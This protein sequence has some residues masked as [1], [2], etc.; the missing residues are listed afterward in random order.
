MGEK[1]GDK[2]WYG[3]CVDDPVNRMDVWGLESG[4]EKPTNDDYNECMSSSTWWN[5]QCKQFV[6][7]GSYVIGDKR[8]VRGRVVGDA[9][10]WLCK[11]IYDGNRQRCE[12]EYGPDRKA[13]D[14]DSPPA[15]SD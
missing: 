10:D 11:E 13:P 5:R 7:F 9:G 6:E 4:T 15:S 1:G 14:N 12:E 8:P 2:D 3:Y